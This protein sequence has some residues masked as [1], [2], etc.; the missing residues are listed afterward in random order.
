[1]PINTSDY[2]VK[3]YGIVCIAASMYSN[4]VNLP[5]YLGDFRISEVLVQTANSTPVCLTHTHK[6]SR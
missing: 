2:H 3:D 5:N 1:M 6:N 4:V